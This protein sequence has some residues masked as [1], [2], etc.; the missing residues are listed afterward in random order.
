[1]SLRVIISGGG[2]GG[3][4]YPGIAI[5]EALKQFR[6][7]VSILFV[8][9][10]GKMEMEKV[11]KAGYQIRGLPIRGFQRGKILVNL[12]L[13]FRI[14]QS[15]WLAWRLLR[16]FRPHVVVGTGGYASW[17]ML[18]VATWTGIPTLI[19]EQNG[20]AG[21]S[22][23]SLAK[24]VTRVCVAYPQME[25]FF[26][27][28]KI[29]LTGNPV[30]S[31][32][33]NLD[34]IRM[35]AYSFFE[36]APAKKTLVVLGGSGGARRINDVLAE[37]LPALLNRDLQIIWQTG[38][39]YFEAYREQFAHLEGKGLYIKPFIYEMN[40]VYACADLVVARAGALS[41]SELA[42]AAK[43][44]ILVP[45]PNVTDDHQ[46]KNALALSTCSA[47]ILIP[48]AELSSRLGLVLA[49]LLPDSDKQLAFSQAIAAFAK[50]N[51]A[52]DIAAEILKLAKK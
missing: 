42:L 27:A 34:S 7:E 11:P 36:F 10:K 43:P 47:A 18:R 51:A 8:G 35:K 39:S 12:A 2:T 31:D 45:S 30:R 29:V 50:P 33:H 20:Y 52:A 9:A 37:Q 49:E 16:G 14:V 4:I 21:L 19:Q 22:N 13:P 41:I 46:M 28:E 25:R 24:S 23:K 26:P 15:L 3:H 40:F 32:L 48:D 6:A 1:M 38:S 5:A 17:A 44:A